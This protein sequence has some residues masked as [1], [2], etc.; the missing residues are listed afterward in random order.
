MASFP[1]ERADAY[2]SRA[3]AVIGRNILLKRRLKRFLRQAHHDNE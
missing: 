1:Q 2:L 3:G